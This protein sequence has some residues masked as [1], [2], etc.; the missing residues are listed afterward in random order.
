MFRVT[1]PTEMLLGMMTAAQ[2]RGQ[3]EERCGRE[4]IVS[5]TYRNL[6]VRK[7]D[8]TSR[9]TPRSDREIRF[10]DNAH[11]E[12]RPLSSAAVDRYIQFC[13][14][15]NAPTKIDRSSRI[16]DAIANE[17]HTVRNKRIDRYQKLMRRIAIAFCAGNSLSIRRFIIQI[18]SL[19]VSP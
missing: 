5:T 7:I 4:I 13:D 10:G 15:E 14:F 9:R 16:S 8:G 19:R 17:T 11:R 18:N 1:K 6:S 12:I 2:H 3:T